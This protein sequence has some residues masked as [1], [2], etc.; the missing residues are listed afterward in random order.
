MF[1]GQKATSQVLELHA[2]DVLHLVLTLHVMRACATK[3]I[4]VLKGDLNH[5]V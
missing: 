1:G 5:C 4:S 3:G 2:A